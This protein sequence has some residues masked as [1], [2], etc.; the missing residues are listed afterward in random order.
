LVNEKIRQSAPG[1]EKLLN[2][3]PNSSAWRETP[4]DLTFKRM[5]S[6]MVTLFLQ[7]FE[8]FKK[9]GRK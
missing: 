2:Q 1:R 9:G 5:G 4:N 3:I 8:I 7:F 6:E